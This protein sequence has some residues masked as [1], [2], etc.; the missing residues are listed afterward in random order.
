MLFRPSD[1]AFLNPRPNRIKQLKEKLMEFFNNYIPFL[2]LAII[3][4]AIFAVVYFAKKDSKH[5]NSA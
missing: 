4:M 2:Y 3:G 1:T 5:K